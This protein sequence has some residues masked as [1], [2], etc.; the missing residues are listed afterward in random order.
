MTWLDTQP[1]HHVEAALA[2]F[3]DQPDLAERYRD[4]AGSDRRYALWLALVDLQSETLPDGRRLR[5][6]DWHT[7]YRTGW[8]PRAAAFAAWASSDNN[9][10]P[11]TP[12]RARHLRVVPG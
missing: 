10:A 7:A 8:S 12:Q 9:P 5:S 1:R 3:D 6:W 2:V 11:E 4:R